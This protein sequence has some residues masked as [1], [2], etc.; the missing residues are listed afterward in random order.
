MKN[1]HSKKLLQK[2]TSTLKEANDKRYAQVRF[3]LRDQTWEIWIDEKP[4]IVNMKDHEWAENKADE[5]NYE[6]MARRAIKTTVDYVKG[7]VV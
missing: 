7:M 5:L 6:Y 4:A 2:V 1:D 3:N